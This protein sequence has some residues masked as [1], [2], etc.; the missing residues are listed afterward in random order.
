MSCVSNIIRNLR[1]LDLVLVLERLHFA[2]LLNL[3]RK[4][5]R[6][7]PVGLFVAGIDKGVEAAEEPK[8]LQIADQGGQVLDRANLESTVLVSNIRTWQAC[9]DAEEDGS[10]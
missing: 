7:L 9:I 6:L 8:F 2:E 10:P 3:A 1:G 5:K 4:V